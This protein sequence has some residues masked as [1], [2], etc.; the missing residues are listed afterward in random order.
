MSAAD[1]PCDAKLLSLSGHYRRR[2]VHLKAGLH[3]THQVD[4]NWTCGSGTVVD[5]Y[6]GATYGVS[7]H[8]VELALVDGQW[9][10]SR[11]RGVEVDR[12]LRGCGLSGP[13]LEKWAVRG[14]FTHAPAQ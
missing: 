1:G 10:V 13:P 2:A 11:F 4:K 14:H 3:W 5:Y 8:A 12:G 6:I 9:V 7:I